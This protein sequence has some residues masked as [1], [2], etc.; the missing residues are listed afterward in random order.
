MVFDYRGRGNSGH[1]SNSANYNLMTDTADT[2]AAITAAGL[3]GAHV[4]GT[5]YGGMVAMLLSAQR[6]GI[7]KS[8]I[9]NEAG[10]QIPGQELVRQK[11]MIERF[12]TETSED[13][14]LGFL[15]S[16]MQCFFPAFSDKDWKDEIKARYRRENGHWI[17]DFDP[18]ILRTL[19]GI[20]LDVRVGEMW[21]EFAGLLNIPAMVI[22]GEMSE[23]RDHPAM[24]HMKALKPDLVTRNAAGQGHAPRLHIGELPG[25]ISSFLAKQ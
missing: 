12:G 22:C 10:S 18:Q 9:L 2:M 6:P 13:A 19:K 4:I 7:L 8:V 14:A 3:H 15:K 1:D 24:Q 20:N 16:Y 21:Q 23:M 11:R 25:H 5:A 17:P